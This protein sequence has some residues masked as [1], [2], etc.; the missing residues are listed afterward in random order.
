M[1]AFKQEQHCLF[2]GNCWNGGIPMNKFI[3]QFALL[4]G[5]LVLF[6]TPASTLA[7]DLNEWTLEEVLHS[8]AEANGGLESIENVTNARFFGEIV[9]EEGA[10][11]FLLLKRR[12]NMVR[13]RLSDSNG[14]METGFDGEIGWQRFERSGFDK[15]VQ[16]EDPKR[17]RSLLLDSDFDGALIGDPQEGV[18]RRLAGIERIDRVDYFIIEVLSPSGTTQHYIDFRTFRELKT[19]KITQS[20]DGEESRIVS[21]YHDNRKHSG[22]WVSHRVERELPDG[23]KETIL[24]HDVE[25]NPGILSR[26]FRMPEEYNPV[27][28]S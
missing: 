6:A 18:T 10:K 2:L 8:I 15:V 9:T 26:A 17:V 20:E 27:P 23:S 12:P 24:I 28:E 4:T 22:I 19:V 11:D 25:M 7:K 13:S 16:I 5:W 14:A 21:L 1:P 3:R